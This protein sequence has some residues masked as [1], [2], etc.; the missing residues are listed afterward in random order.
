MRG[1]VT[2]GGREKPGGSAGGSLPL[3]IFP[4]P[5]GLAEGHL[6]AGLIIR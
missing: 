5:S 3:L 4:V 1:N 2:G 6:V